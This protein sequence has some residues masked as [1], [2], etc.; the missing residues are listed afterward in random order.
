MLNNF[1]KNYTMFDYF[2][3]IQNIIITAT[4]K[5]HAHKK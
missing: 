4:V 3:K 5:K 1:L 2:L